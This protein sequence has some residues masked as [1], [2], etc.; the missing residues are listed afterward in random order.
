M[1][2]HKK[3]KKQEKHEKKLKKLMRKYYE[4]NRDGY[5]E[6]VIAN[7]KDEGKAEGIAIGEAKA[8]GEAKD[9]VRKILLA[10]ARTLLAEGM[11]RLKVQRYTQLSDAEMASICE[12]N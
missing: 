10:A 11:D 4:E 9:E 2:A 1:S 8:K 12:V 5:W 6:G 7:A 3:K